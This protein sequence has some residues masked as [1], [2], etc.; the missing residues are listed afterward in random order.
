LLLAKSCTFLPSK[1]IQYSRSRI[2]RHRRDLARWVVKLYISSPLRDIPRSNDHMRDWFIELFLISMC[3]SSKAKASTLGK[4]SA[5]GRRKDTP[6]VSHIQRCGVDSIQ[7]SYRADFTSSG[8]W[9]SDLSIRIF[10][11]VC[12]SFRVRSSPQHR[13]SFS[14]CYDSISLPT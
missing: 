8:R 3:T 5:S 10:T 4:H 1:E 6:R 2:F 14:S 9:L 13:R 7:C 12:C 11:H